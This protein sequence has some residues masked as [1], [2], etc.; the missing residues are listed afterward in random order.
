MQFR[1][2]KPSDSKIVTMPTNVPL[3]QWTH[4]LGT[5]ST[6]NNGEA[7]IYTNG[8]VSVVGNLSTNAIET[9]Y[10]WQIGRDL[11]SDPARRYY[12]YIDEEA[13]WKRRLNYREVLAVYQLGHGSD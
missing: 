10:V 6:E 7:I 12:G 1:M 13:I 11:Y 3:N 2:C 8:V 9:G 5:W 4:V